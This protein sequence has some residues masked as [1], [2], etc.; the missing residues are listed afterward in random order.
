MAT[1]RKATA[2]EKQVMLD[3]LTKHENYQELL[4]AKVK[5]D[6]LFAYPPKDKDGKYSDADALTHDGHKA[7][8]LARIVNLRDRTKGCGDCE[9]TMDGLHWED[10]P[11]KEREALMDHELYHFIVRKDQDNVILR[12]DLERPKI[13]LRHH[14]VQFGWFKEVAKRNGEHSQERMQA[15]AMMDNGGQYFWPVIAKQLA[16]AA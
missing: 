5:I 12:D 2:E 4:D 7:L 9:I 6:L 15:K 1:F 8:G 13:K 14:D 16:A 3:V 10:A 11:E